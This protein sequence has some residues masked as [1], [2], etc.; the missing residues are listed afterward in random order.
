MNT[1]RSHRSSET[2][3]LRPPKKKPPTNKMRDTNCRNGGLTQ[4]QA[5]AKAG[6]R[7]PRRHCPPQTGLSIFREVWG[8]VKPHCCTKVLHSRA[9]VWLESHN[10]SPLTVVHTKNAI[11]NNVYFASRFENGYSTT[12]SQCRH[13]TGVLPSRRSRGSD[14]SPV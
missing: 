13:P 11:N 8:S 3:L 7:L 1:V 12:K 5:Q 10:C 2:G 4:A 9:G 14:P 6:Y